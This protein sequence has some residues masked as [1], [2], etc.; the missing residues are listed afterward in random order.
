LL[1]FL[2]WMGKML[3]DLLRVRQKDWVVRGAVAVMIA[4]LAAGWYEHNLGNGDVV[5][6]FLGVCACGYLPVAKNEKDTVASIP[7]TV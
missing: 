3:V 6:L 5:P 4:V 2:W 7:A 1:A